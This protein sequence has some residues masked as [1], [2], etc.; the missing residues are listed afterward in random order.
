V[1]ALEEVSHADRR[2]GRD[3]GCGEGSDAALHTE[4]LCRR[5]PMSNGTAS[6][7]RR[8]STSSARTP[9]LTATRDSHPRFTRMLRPGPRGRRTGPP[10]SGPARRAWPGSR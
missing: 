2:H 3:R 10:V 1:V 7:D 9:R 5:D 6:A 4:H 8:R